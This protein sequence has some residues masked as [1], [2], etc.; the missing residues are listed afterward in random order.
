VFFPS[1]ARFENE[2]D[3]VK[4]DAFDMLMN[5]TRRDADANDL[6]LNALFIIS[7]MFVVYEGTGI[8]SKNLLCTPCRYYVRMYCKM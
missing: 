5:I 7:A 1:K 3:A 4:H 2:T 6:I 8:L